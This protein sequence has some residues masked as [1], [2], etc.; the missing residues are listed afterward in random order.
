MALIFRLRWVF[1]VLAAFFS[2]QSAAQQMTVADVLGKG[3]K[4]LT[5]DEVMVLLKDTYVSGTTDT[6]AK[7]EIFV[8][9]DGGVKGDSMLTSGTKV[10]LEGKWSVNGSGKFITNM[11]NSRGA[12]WTGQSIF[13]KADDMFYTADNDAPSSVVSRRELRK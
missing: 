4:V 5:K 8:T 1:A 12:R 2:L 9:A 7:F 6:G 3:G 13:L 10:A 11:M